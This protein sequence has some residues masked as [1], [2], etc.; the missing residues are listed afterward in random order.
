[1]DTTQIVLRAENGDQQAFTELYN[2]SFKQAYSVAFQMTKSE[3]D[4]YD[5]IQEAYIKAFGSLSLLTDKSG[6]VPW[7]NK[8]VSNKCKDFLR[9]KK[10]V[11]LFSDM[12]YDSGEGEIELDFEDES[13]TFQ[14]EEN[15]DYGETKRIVAEM[16]DNLPED[17]KLVLLMFYV[18]EMSIR[19]IAEA[20]EISENTVKSRMSYGKKKMKAQA[21]ELEKK[22]VKLRVSVITLIPFLMWMLR[23]NVIE[24]PVY[25]MSAAAKQAAAAS[26]YSGAAAAHSS[27]SGAAAG[28]AQSGAAVTATA[29]AASAAGG[30]SAK[31][32][33]II[34][35]AAVTLIAGT[36]VFFTV[37][38]PAM[39]N[40]GQTDASSSSVKSHSTGILTLE[41][42]RQH[43]N[44]IQE[45]IKEKSQMS[46]AFELANTYAICYA[47]SDTT[48]AREK[49]CLVFLCKGTKYSGTAHK[50]Y[51][52]FY[53]ANP[54]IENGKLTGDFSSQ[55]D[56]G[57][58]ALSKSNWLNS[59]IIKKNE[60]TLIWGEE[61]LLN[62]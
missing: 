20:L 3:Q 37:A 22:G 58:G 9:S 38:L 19:E 24:T 48:F 28:T 36:V 34:A 53:L 18:Q 7:F 23:K 43:L 57:G 27:V 13:K 10:N 15:V 29:K 45:Y 46:Y 16:L 51:K 26:A 21:E 11:T 31:V 6:F 33:A 30:I 35:A 62:E 47:P 50:A 32:I 4:A 40:G 5:I 60:V 56:N 42:A 12:T 17:Q 41:E 1:M 61:E 14:P 44:E 49:V 25:A 39:Q 8:I 52:G 54:R 2:I 55:N 59:V